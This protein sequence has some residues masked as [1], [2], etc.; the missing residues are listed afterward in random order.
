MQVDSG[1][2]HR[3]GVWT[4]AS[5]EDTLLLAIPC[6]APTLGQTG[7]KRLQVQVPTQQSPQQLS[8]TALEQTRG[9]TEAAALDVIVLRAQKRTLYQARTG[10]CSAE[11]RNA[12]DASSGRPAVSQHQ[13]W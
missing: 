13:L 9:E 6:P 11:P 3:T 7:Q 5:Q 8:C 1:T 10:I 2:L 12:A 4:S